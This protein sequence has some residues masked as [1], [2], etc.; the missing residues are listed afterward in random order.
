[1]EKELLFCRYCLKQI[2]FLKI[3]IHNFARTCIEFAS[4]QFSHSPRKG[5]KEEGSLQR[6][7]LSHS[8]GDQT[9]SDR[10]SGNV[11]YTQVLKDD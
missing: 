11:M 7:M 2:N 8:F 6:Q 10:K 1:M 5:P 4:L 3:I 9:S